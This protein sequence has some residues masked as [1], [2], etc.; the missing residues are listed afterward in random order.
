MI[1]STRIAQRAHF[2]LKHGSKLE[3]SLPVYLTQLISYSLKG[4]HFPMRK[5][6]HLKS[7]EQEPE[8]KQKQA[9]TKTRT[10]NKNSNNNNHS[11][12]KEC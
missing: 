5:T 8:Q 6:S 9:R 1:P 11:F 4:R 10:F 3:F 2:P 12:L 7:L